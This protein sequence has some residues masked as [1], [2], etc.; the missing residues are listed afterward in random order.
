MG[1]NFYNGRGYGWQVKQ[2]GGLRAVDQEVFP[3][4]YV[5]SVSVRVFLLYLHHGT[6]KI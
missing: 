2:T 3:L 5:F 6:R 1:N 4:L